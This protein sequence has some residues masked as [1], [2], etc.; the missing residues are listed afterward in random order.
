MNIKR[1]CVAAIAAT[2]LALGANAQ[3]ERPKLVVGIVVDQ[4]RWDFFYTH[5]DRFGKGGF[6]RLLAEGLAFNN[7]MI[8]YVPTVTACGHASIYTGTTPAVH[9]IAGSSFYVNN[10]KVSS[11]ADATVQGVGTNGK[12]GQQSPRNLLVTTLGDQ[13]KLA[14]D[15]RSR[16]F[17]VALKERAAIL[18]GGHAAD[19]AFWFDSEVPAFITSD[20]YMTKLPKWLTKYNDKQRKFLKQDQWSSYRGVR[21]TMEVARLIIDNEDLGKDD[22]PDLLAISISSTDATQHTYSTRSLRTDSCYL[23]FDRQLAE[24]LSKLDSKVGKGKY[25]VFL[26]ADHGGTHNYNY[27]NSHKLPSGAWNPWSDINKL[28]EYLNGATGVEKLIKAV[29]EYSF[30]LDNDKIAASKLDR[31]QV[32]VLAV[33]WLQ[34]RPDVQWAVDVEHLDGVTMP[35]EIKERIAR[36]YHPKR[37]GEIYVIP[38]TGYFAGNRDARGSNHGSWNQSDSHIPCVFMGWGVTHGEQSRKVAITDI[39]PTVCSMLHIQAPDGALGSPLF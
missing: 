19:G 7:C 28:N 26:T 33:Q 38:I 36:G 24:L 29:D 21:S 3:I 8:D 2:A 20:Y 16:V 1:L 31:E 34:A 27:M 22:V 32:K 12:A 25:L 30:Y 11:V 6:K 9:G 13:M 37:S 18:P 17:A 23:E 39:I 4:M 35:A 14:T 5:Y 15:F 10:V